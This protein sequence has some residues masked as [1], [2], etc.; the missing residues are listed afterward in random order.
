MTTHLDTG[1]RADAR[2]ASSSRRAPLRALLW[3]LV[4]GLGACASNKPV[5]EAPS[6]RRP[7]EVEAQSPLAEVPDDCEPELEADALPP[8]KYNERSVIEAKNLAEDGFTSLNRAEDGKLPKPER[9]KLIVEAVELFV[10]ALQ[11]DPYNVHAT[12]N[13]SA[14]YARIGRQQCA[15]NL[16]E[17][18]VKLH[19]LPSLHDEVET[20]LDR[21]LGR[22]RYRNDLD[23]DFFELRDEE[24]FREVIRKFNK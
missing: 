2:A 24:N 13:L 19:R 22:G 3:A 21:L 6:P 17:R 10:T 18:L 8:I 4:L 23:P 7:A 12:Y 15:V 9:E 14:A 5:P 20:K 1:A 11:A 16:L